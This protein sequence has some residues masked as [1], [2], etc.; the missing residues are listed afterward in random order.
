VREGQL[1]QSREGIQRSLEQVAKARKRLETMG[2]DTISL[3]C[4]KE[5]E[6]K[7]GEILKARY[8]ADTTVGLMERN[9]GVL[10][11]GVAAPALPR[12]VKPLER[13][14]AARRMG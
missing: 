1:P 12:E 2:N 3:G 13:N 4:L 6:T 5:I 11:R 10:G 7:W 9:K 8:G 14:Y